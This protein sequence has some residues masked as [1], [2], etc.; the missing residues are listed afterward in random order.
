MNLSIQQ[1]DMYLTPAEY[2]HEPTNFNG[3]Y[4]KE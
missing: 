2:A 3:E 1:E 4:S